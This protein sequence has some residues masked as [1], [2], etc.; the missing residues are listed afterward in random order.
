MSRTRRNFS[1]AFKSAIV[2][3]L[4][5]GERDL[6]SIAAEHQI[7]PNLLRNWKKE[8]IEKASVVFDESREEILKAKLSAERRE[9]EQ[10]APK[11]G[12][13][14]MHVDWLKKNL[15]KSLELTTQVNLVR[16]LSR[17]K[18]LPIRNSAKLL[19]IN[20]ISIYYHKPPYLWKSLLVK[21]Q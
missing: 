17:T 13:L 16:N 19:G 9:K 15:R 6:N 21:R 18:E 11:V 5:K 8:F 20:R 10:Y 2:L 14:T 12:Q 4:L 3:E 1:P 7:A